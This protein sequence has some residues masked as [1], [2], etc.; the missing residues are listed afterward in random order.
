[1]KW[2]AVNTD[3]CVCT[4]VNNNLDECLRVVADRRRR[5][6]I[7]QLRFESGGGVAFDDLFEAL[8]RSESGT[9]SE[10][11]RIALQF[12]HVH[13][14]RLEAYGVIEYDRESGV[15]QYRPDAVIEAVLD[16]VPEDASPKLS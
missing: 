10:R 16:A 6:L 1:M 7:R 8:F 9:E 11:E 3:A 13:L 12:W 14:P 4:L 2:Y 15:V 5:E